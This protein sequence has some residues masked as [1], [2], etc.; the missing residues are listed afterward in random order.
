MGN[1]GQPKIT[2]YIKFVIILNMTLYVGN[3]PGSTSLYDLESIFDKF[4]PNKIKQKTR[5][6]QSAHFTFIEFRNKEDA[7]D[8]YS[9]LKK[10][11]LMINDCMLTI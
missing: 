8:A 7:E 3:L 6:K 10:S 11:G 2:F 1:I 5:F 4:G 9:T